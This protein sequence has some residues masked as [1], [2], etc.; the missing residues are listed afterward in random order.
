MFKQKLHLCQ[1]AGFYH[2]VETVTLHITYFESVLSTSLI[3][4][5]G[6]ILNFIE[7]TISLR[8]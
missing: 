4:F 2:Q 5:W 7:N 1:Q 8:E 3:I 6:R